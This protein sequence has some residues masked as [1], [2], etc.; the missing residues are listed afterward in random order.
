MVATTNMKTTTETTTTTTTTTT[1]TTLHGRGSNV[2]QLFLW[3]V[4]AIDHRMGTLSQANKS[5]RVPTIDAFSRIVLVFVF[6]SSFN[7]IISNS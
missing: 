3:S 1:I 2:V 7:G 6:E 4:F 5:N